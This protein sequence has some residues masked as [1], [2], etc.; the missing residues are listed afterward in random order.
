MSLNDTVP[1]QNNFTELF[2]MISSTKI[3]QLILLDQSRGLPWSQL[4]ISLTTSHPEP[5]VQI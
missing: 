4:E 5:M 2:L 1:I 3:A